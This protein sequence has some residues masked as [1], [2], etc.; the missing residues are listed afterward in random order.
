MK[1]TDQVAAFALTNVE[2]EADNAGLDAVIT[3]TS[4]HGHLVV[5]GL[6]AYEIACLR[7]LVDESDVEWLSS[8]GDIPG[9]RT[10]LDKLRKDVD[11]NTSD[12]AETKKELVDGDYAVRG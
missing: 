3:I 9:M 7:G 10:I 2:G 6:D 1:I 11:A 5:D 8:I 12:I 4:Q